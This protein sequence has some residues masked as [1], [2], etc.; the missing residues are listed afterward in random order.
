MSGR[1]VGNV[2]GMITSI[3]ISEERIC[4]TKSGLSHILTVSPSVRMGQ[5]FPDLAGFS[6]VETACYKIRFTGGIFQFKIC[7]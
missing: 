6:P 2:C 5:D 3:K 7:S 1:Q 4:T